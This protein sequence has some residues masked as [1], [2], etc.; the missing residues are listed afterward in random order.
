MSHCKTCKTFFV[1]VSLSLYVLNL[2]TIK[3]DP[4]HC[5]MFARFSHTNEKLPCMCLHVF[6][7]LF[8]RI[9][10]IDRRT[11]SVFFVVVIII[12]N[13][14]LLPFTL[15]VFFSSSGVSTPD[16]VTL[17]CCSFMTVGSCTHVCV[18]HCKVYVHACV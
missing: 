3:D 18:C 6:D 11:Q 13:C 10:S 17:C 12:I 8:E 2:M 9:K 16:V 4:M 15:F 7:Y 1:L 14:P 5:L